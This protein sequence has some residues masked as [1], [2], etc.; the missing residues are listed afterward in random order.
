MKKNCKFFIF[1]LPIR[2]YN[3]ITCF[4]DCSKL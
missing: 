2:N 4:E 3:S 1:R